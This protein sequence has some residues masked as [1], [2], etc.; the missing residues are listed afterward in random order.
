MNSEVYL[1]VSYFLSKDMGA[2]GNHF[3]GAHDIMGLA[4]KAI[5]QSTY[6]KFQCCHF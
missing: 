2:Q 1:A 5:K 6:H 3:A 4:A